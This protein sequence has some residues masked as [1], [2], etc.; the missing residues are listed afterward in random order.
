MDSRSTVSK[1][2]P[3]Q[4]NKTNDKSEDPTYKN[5]DIS[6]ETTGKET[7][8]QINTP[9][10]GEIEKEALAALSEELGKNDDEEPLTPKGDQ[11]SDNVKRGETMNDNFGLP[12]DFDALQS[13]DTHDV[14]AHEN[15]LKEL[16]EEEVAKQNNRHRTL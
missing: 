12:K 3:V 1:Q 6:K 15:E 5:V 11:L 8:E 10:P 7:E 4:T 13:P 9:T 14:K 2:T 16:Y